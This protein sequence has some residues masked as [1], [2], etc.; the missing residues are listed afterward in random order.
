MKR[1]VSGIVL[2]FSLAV[3]LAGC[4]TGSKAVIGDLSQTASVEVTVYP[5][6]GHRTMSYVISD[7][8]TIQD[9]CE[10]FSSL[11]LKKVRIVKPIASTYGVSFYD[12]DGK[13]MNGA[14][15][16]TG[17]VI[18]CGDKL[19]KV[20]NDIDIDAFVSDIALQE[21]EQLFETICNAKIGDC[22]KLGQ[23][24]HVPYTE[25]EDTAIEWQV[26]DKKGGKVLLLSRYGLDSQAYH[27]AEEEV[28]WE[29]CTLR[30][31]LNEE[32]YK[33][34]FNEAERAHIAETMLVNADNGETGVD[35]GNDTTDKVFLLSMDE[36]LTYFDPDPDV[37]DPERTV[38][39]TKYAKQ[40]GGDHSTEEEYYGNGRWL[41]RSPGAN[42]YSAAE[43]NTA[44][45]VGYFGSDVDIQGVIRPA[46]WVEP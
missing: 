40:R 31:W 23:Y 19:Y 33:E 15:L 27:E 16:I 1:V 21:E 18:D 39:L 30:T 42:A 13:R 36:V 44:G 24:E 45:A 43:I 8:E 25:Y 3:C 22:V 6:T 26:L 17:N 32:F 34:A 12:G 41:L 46:I 4:K 37:K 5:K 10:M 28:T 20:L 11:E 2:I 38:K 7:K 9:I 29:T 14:T 35:G